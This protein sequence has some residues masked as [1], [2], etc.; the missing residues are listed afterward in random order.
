MGC[1]HG[2]RYAPV[3]DRSANNRSAQTA[4]HKPRSMGSPQG[5]CQPTCRR[6]GT[7]AASRPAR[8]R[9]RLKTPSRPDPPQK[10]SS[11]LTLSE[12]PARGGGGAPDDGRLPLLALAKLAPADLVPAAAVRA[13]PAATR[14]APPRR[15]LA[16][17]AT[18]V[19]AAAAAGGTAALAAPP[20]GLPPPAGGNGRGGAA[21]GDVAW[22]RLL[23]SPRLPVDE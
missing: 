12:S 16:P 4:Q 6:V 10:S 13:A 1:M 5:G 17:R 23:L 18:P 19:A 7:S 20:P 22:P 21:R 8:G 2:Q 14:A 11:E 9:Q 3:K 15:D